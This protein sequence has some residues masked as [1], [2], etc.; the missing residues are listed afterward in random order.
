MNNVAPH[1]V[2]GA[3][4]VVKGSG[5]MGLAGK[6]IGLGESELQVG[7]PWWS[8]LALGTVGGV[9]LGY[10]YKEKIQRVIG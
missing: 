9:A 10:I 1:L 3:I 4:P 8:W 2:N 6:I 7:L 5:P